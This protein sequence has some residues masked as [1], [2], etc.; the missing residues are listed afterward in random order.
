MRRRALFAVLSLAAL[1]GG[2][3]GGGGTSGP[4]TVTLR[5]EAD[6]T[7][8]VKADGTVQK[9]F[10]L[11]ISVG[12]QRSLFGAMGIR[13]F[14]S[15]DLSGIPADAKVS[16][17]TFTLVQ[18]NVV[19]TPYQSLGSVFV[20]Q[21]SYGN[22]LDGGAYSRSFPVNQGLGPISTDATLAPKSLVVTAV[23][24]L[25]LDQSRGQAQFRLRC[26]VETDSDDEQDVAQFRSTQAL[27]PADSPALVVTYTH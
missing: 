21:V 26:P 13:G 6:L 3:G 9:G 7:G 2:C 4:V 8:H 1:C 5:S 18:D 16:S 20:D 24:Q 25:C 10:G 11:D 27:V 19:F 15:F 14:V 17:A 12:D 23:V 22:L